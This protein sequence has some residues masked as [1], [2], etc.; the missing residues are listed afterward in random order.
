MICAAKPRYTAAAAREHGRVLSPLLHTSG[1]SVASLF[2]MP[3]EVSYE[4]LQRFARLSRIEEKVGQV[5][6]SM[7]TTTIQGSQKPFLRQTHFT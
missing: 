2:Y 7:F 5:Q 1:T 4:V 6:L 3:R